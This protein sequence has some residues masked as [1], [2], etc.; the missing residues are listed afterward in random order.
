MDLY[1][2]ISLSKLILSDNLLLTLT[3]D[4][5]CI[6]VFA[7]A[8]SGWDSLQH[9]PEI[10]LGHVVTSPEGNR[11]CKVTKKEK[12]HVMNKQCQPW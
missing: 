1:F 3:D 8:P 7:L 2:S 4:V 6:H 11:L 9:E 10:K 5:E 12:K